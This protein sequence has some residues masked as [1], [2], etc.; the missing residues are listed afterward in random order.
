MNEKKIVQIIFIT[1]CIYIIVGL[2]CTKNIQRNMIVV[3]SSSFH[4]NSHS[5]VT[6]GNK[7]MAVPSPGNGMYAVAIKRG[8]FKDIT[9]T[10]FIGT[11]KPSTFET[12]FEKMDIFFEKNKKW[13]A[14]IF[15]VFSVGTT[16]VKPTLELMRTGILEGSFENVSN[17]LKKYEMFKFI[18]LAHGCRQPYVMIRDVKRGITKEKTGFTGGN[19]T[20]KA[21][22]G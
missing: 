6:L 16:H 19:L 17:I 14:S 1:I 4:E 2:A 21:I 13:G 15:T 9:R 22:I 18:G 8:M 5:M 7:N 11:L 10:L 20:S 3:K 12:Q